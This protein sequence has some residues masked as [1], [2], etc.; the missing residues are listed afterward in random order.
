M[1][2]NKDGNEKQDDQAQL[3]MIAAFLPS[4]ELLSLCWVSLFPHACSL[5]LVANTASIVTVRAHIYALHHSALTLCP[6]PMHPVNHFAPLLPMCTACSHDGDVV[7]LFFA[8]QP[9]LCR[10]YTTVPIDQC[11]K[12]VHFLL[13]LLLSSSKEVLVFR[14]FKRSPISEY[15][16][17]Q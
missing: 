15:L 17:K 14:L 5:N 13:P 11:R 1:G 6:S 16:V 8:L 9:L 4:T 7:Y 12:R 10:D 3:R 2:A